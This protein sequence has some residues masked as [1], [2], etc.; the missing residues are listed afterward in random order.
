MVG[1]DIQAAL[2]IVERLESI[3][4]RAEMFGKSKED[5]LL[6]IEFMA[7]D[8][9]ELVERIERSMEESYRG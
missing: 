1:Y 2:E 5:L 6:D 9:S 3:K 8:Y 7:Q 4:R